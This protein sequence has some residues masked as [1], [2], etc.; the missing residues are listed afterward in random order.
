MKY[1]SYLF[2]LFLIPALFALNSAAQSPNSILKNATKALGIE[3]AQKSVESWRKSGLITRLKDGSEGEFHA[4]AISPNYYHSL[5]DLNGFEIEVGANGRSG[6]VRDSREGLRTLVGDASRDFQAEVEFRNL[7]WLDYKKQ[8]AKIKSGGQMTLDGQLVN[9]IIFTNAQA[10][11]IK[12]YFDARTSLLIRE[13][14]PAAGNVKS[15]T[16][17]DYRPVNG[18]KEAFQIDAVIDGEAYKIQLDQIVHNEKI[19]KQKFNFPQISG[20]PLPDIPKLIGELQANENK[21]EAILENYSFNQK[22]SKR[23]LGKDGILRE[24]ESETY[25][26]TFYKGNRIRRLIEKNGKPLSV[27]DQE[28]EDREVQKR[29]EDIEKRIAKEEARSVDRSANAEPDENER[30]ISIAELLQASNLINPRRERLKGRDVI[31]FDFEPNPNFDFRNAKSFLKF[32][33]KTGGVMWIDEKDKQVA[34]LEAELFDS[35]KIGGGLLAK[36]RKGASFVLE[37][38]RI[39]NEIWLPSVAD[40]NLSVRVLLFGGVNVNQLISSYGYNRFNT[41][42]QDSKIGDVQK[43]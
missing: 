17:S 11:S 19:D 33:G 4:Q 28:K 20:E 31:V 23:E 13:E 16:Y 43:P 5:Y 6:W 36:L 18:V 25:F 32:F 30:R 15:F 8:K 27:K 22:T 38:D 41:E 9:M 21:I 10:V 34:R 29:I 37:Q 3:K 42:V 35:Y 7:R 1:H 24:I 26:L 2:S 39:N 40:I 14:I 12:L